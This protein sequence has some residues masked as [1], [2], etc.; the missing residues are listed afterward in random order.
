MKVSITKRY[1][2]KQ[3]YGGFG[4]A[5]AEQVTLQEKHPDQT[6]TVEFNERSS[7]T[8]YRVVRLR[9]VEVEVPEAPETFDYNRPKPVKIPDKDLS[10]DT[11]STTV[12]DM[13]NRNIVQR[14]VVLTHVPSGTT[15]T[16]KLWGM[17]NPDKWTKGYTIR[18]MEEK[19]DPT[20]SDRLKE[21]STEVRRHQDLMTK[22]RIE[23]DEAIREA[24]TLA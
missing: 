17:E 22:W 23:C 11:T 3:S 14:H 13:Y 16:R 18:D 24:N 10:F 15:V 1:C 20:F 7:S 12:T 2:Y 4:S 9:Q 8:V 6:I 21:Y 5:L 19:L